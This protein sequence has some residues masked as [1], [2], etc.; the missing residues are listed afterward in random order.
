MRHGINGGIICHFCRREISNCGIVPGGDKLPASFLPRMSQTGLMSG[1]YAGQSIR[2][3]PSSKRK[4]ST[5]RAR[6]GLALSSLRTDLSPI[7]Y[8]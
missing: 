5:I 1:E 7:A 8:V 6:C 2:R 3:I 4:F